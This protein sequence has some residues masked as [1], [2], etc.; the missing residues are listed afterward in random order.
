MATR[1]EVYGALDSE[2]AYQDSVW[3]GDHHDTAKNVEAWLVYMKV[4]LDKAFD[5]ITAEPNEIAIPK[6]M[7]TIRKVSALG[8]AAMEVLGA[9][10]REGF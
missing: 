8:V 2:R 4:Y 10:R 6:A 5:Q 3:G 1:Q 7:H 9:H